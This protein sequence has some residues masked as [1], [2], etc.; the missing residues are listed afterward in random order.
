MADSLGDLLRNYDLDEPPEIRRIKAY[1]R[2]KFQ[3]DVSVSIYDNQVAI[4]VPSAALA[5]ALRPQ[6]YKIKK[7]C[8][9][10]KRLTIRINR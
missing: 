8:E 7:D 6:L 10:E 3:K 5:G 4:S 9:I 1:I 2:D